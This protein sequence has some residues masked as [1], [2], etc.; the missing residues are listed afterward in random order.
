MKA[1]KLFLAGILFVVTATFASAQDGFNRAEF[2]KE[3]ASGGMMEVKLGNMAQQKASSQ[4]VKDFGERMVQDHSK[5][6]EQLKQLAKNNNY[7]VPDQMIQKHQDKVNKLSALSGENFDKAY[8]EMMVE[9]H[10][11]DID[12]FQEAAN[13]AIDPEIKAFASKT[14]PTLKEHYQLAQT[15][16]EKVD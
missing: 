8:M 10:E 5:A 15:V 4:A 12:K 16:E 2:I 6:N 14:L 11:E 9:D 7:R 1:N 13:N 3:A